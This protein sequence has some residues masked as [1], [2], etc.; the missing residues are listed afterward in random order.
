MDLVYVAVGTAISYGINLQ[1]IWDTVHKSNMQKDPSL[2]NEDGKVLKPK[3]WTPPDLKFQIA[4][5][6]VTGQPRGES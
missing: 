1:P 3:K 5:Q 4:Q 6:V 2:K